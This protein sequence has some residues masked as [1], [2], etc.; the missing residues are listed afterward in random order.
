MKILFAAFALLLLAGLA[1][2]DSIW[3]YQGNSA[4]DPAEGY[5]DIAAQTFVQPPNP[6]SCAIAGSVTLSDADVPVLW[7][8]TAGAI[9]LT[10]ANSS[11]L[12]NDHGQEP[13]LGNLTPFA[14]WVMHIVGAGAV[15]TSSN[16]YAFDN[17]SLNGQTYQ[18]VE[19]RPGVWTESVATPE[20]GTMALIGVGLAG[21]L[22]RR[23][24]QARRN[25]V[26][27]ALWEPLA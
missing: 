14:G 19:G 17:I 6:C 2:A 1:R 3:N 27:E 12:L 25:Q 5:L 18:D 16:F 23:R 7:S 15:M 10:Q 9:T 11:M 26:P 4:S 13:W 24:L 20:P 22:A 8:F 21:L